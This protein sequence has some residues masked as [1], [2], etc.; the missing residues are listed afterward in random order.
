M[1]DVV[2]ILGDGSKWGNNEIKYSLRSLEKYGKNI[3]D[4]YICGNKPYFVNNKIK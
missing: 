3:R 2:Y 4:V 1:I